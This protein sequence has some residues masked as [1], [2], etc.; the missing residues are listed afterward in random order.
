MINV[1][2]FYN[3]NINYLYILKKIIT[4]STIDEKEFVKFC[5]KCEKEEKNE[6]VNDVHLKV[7]EEILTWIN[8]SNLPEQVD[9]HL[10]QNIS[11]EE[12]KEQEFNICT[13]TKKDMLI[14]LNSSF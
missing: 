11:N 8:D 2:L 6:I 7:I 4:V 14:C 12:A 5:E 13:Q 1:Y 10:M 3:V 9:E